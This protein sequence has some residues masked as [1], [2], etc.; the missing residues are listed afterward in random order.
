VTRSGE[1]PGSAAPASSST[2]ATS[3]GGWRRT[4]RSDD[5]GAGGA[6]SPRAS[7]R[8]PSGT[9]LRGL[10][11]PSGGSQDVHR[12]GCHDDGVTETRQTIEVRLR[13]PQDTGV[14]A[15]ANQFAAQLAPGTD[16]R[17]EAVLVTVGQATPPLVAGT[18][19]EQKAQ[20]SEIDHV[21]VR[22]LS[23]FSLTRGQ[24]EQ[25]LS[26]L[27]TSLQQWDQIGDQAGEQGGGSDEQ[28]ADAE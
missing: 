12:P 17:P 19:E 24:L 10:G 3:H 6:G 20:M 25:L 21:D 15:A 4:G 27:S 7:S 28:H 11:D 26:V 8:L 9:P 18:P 22:I 13:W 1:P 5:P 14:M 2:A 23:R 16:G